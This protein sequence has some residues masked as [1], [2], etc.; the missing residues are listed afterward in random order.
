MADDVVVG[1]VVGDVVDGVVDGVVA[2]ASAVP[3]QNIASVIS[4][5]I[6]ALAWEILPYFLFSPG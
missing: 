6:Q 5:S 1:G 2:S 3:P 4:P